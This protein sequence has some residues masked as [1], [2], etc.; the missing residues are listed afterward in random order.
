VLYGSGYVL[1]AFIQGELVEHLGWLTPGELLDAV[2]VGQITP[3]PLFTTA[4][5]VGYV[6]GVRHGTGG[7][8]TGLLAT[9]GIFLPAFVFVAVTGPFIHRLRRSAYAAA[10]LDGIIA[11]SLA[12]MAAAAIT[13]ARTAV[14]DFATGAIAAV[15][16]VILIRYKTNSTWLIAGAAP[17]GWIAHVLGYL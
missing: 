3:G 13:L 15:S 10:M 5:F 2:A 1:I 6:L 12:L 14:T 7:P 4:T 8:L 16:A 11:A 9:A 17:L